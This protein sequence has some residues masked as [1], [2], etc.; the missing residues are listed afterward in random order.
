MG[1]DAII[2]ITGPRTGCS[3]LQAAQPRPLSDDI[4]PRIGMLAKV[5]QGGEIGVGT[6][7]VPITTPAVTAS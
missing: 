7:V 5:I 2:E 1:H 4:Q 3:R 6:A